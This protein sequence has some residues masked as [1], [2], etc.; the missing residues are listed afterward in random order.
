MRDYRQ[1]ATALAIVFACASAGCTTESLL[2]PFGNYYHYTNNTIP[3]TGGLVE[4]FTGQ[5]AT[6]SSSG[7][8]G[9]Q[10]GTSTGSTGTTG[11]TGTT[12]TT[13]TSDSTGSQT[14][15]SSPNLD[16]DFSG[17]SLGD[18]EVLSGTWSVVSGAVEGSAAPVGGYGILAG[19]SA[20]WGDYELSVDVYVLS[21]SECSLGVRLQAEDTFYL[22]KHTLTGIASIVEVQDGQQS[23]L[24][25]RSSTPLLPGEW[26]TF[27]IV[28]NDNT[29]SFYLE[30][31]LVDTTTD[32]SSPL[33][34]GRV[35]L[36]VA[37][38][39]TARFDNVTVTPVTGRSRR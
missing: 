20:S 6:P 39:T 4:F 23:V 3:G 12:D 1:F 24:T 13:D 22:C 38:G 2:W 14:G 9:T 15:G 27:R 30:G 21:G 11:T 34:T 33:G 8:T 31:E 26:Y 28:A 35:A 18:W 7:L 37:S 36:M 17:G 5:G 25:S 10:T 32:T 19:G 29:I 16:E